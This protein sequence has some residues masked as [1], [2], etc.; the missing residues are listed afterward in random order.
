MLKRKH[1]AKTFADRYGN[2][3]KLERKLSANSYLQSHKVG[4]KKSL[5]QD[6]VMTI[7]LVRKYSANKYYNVKYCEETF[8]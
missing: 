7:K 2:I 5:L 4:K 3:M 8:K 6:N 1:S